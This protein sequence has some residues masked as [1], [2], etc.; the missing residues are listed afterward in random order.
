MELPGR[1]RNGPL[2]LPGQMLLMLDRISGF[3]PDEGRAGLG[4]VRAEKDVDAGE[5]F[6]KAHFFTDPVQPGSLG[7]EAMC[8]L[9][10][11]YL[12]ETDAGAGLPEPRFEPLL[13]GRTVVWK[14]RGQVT[15]SNELVIIDLEVT[16]AGIDADGC[17]YAVADASLWVDGK[18]IYQVNGL[19]SRVLSASVV[20]EEV[21][22][23][24][25]EPWLAD[26]CPTWTVPAVPATVIADRL[27]AAAAAHTGRSVAGLRQVHISR[28]LPVPARIRT[29][30]QVAGDEA[31]ATLYGW[32][33]SRTAALSRF[34]PVATSQVLLGDPPGPRP[35]VPEPL[36]DAAPVPDPYKSGA[37]FH[38]PRLQYVTSAWLG[39]TGASA[40]LDPAR[41]AMPRGLLHPG[42]LDGALQ[43]CPCDRMWRWSADIPR[44]VIAY[45]YRIDRLD[46][47]EPL[48]D[49]GTM[50]GEARFAGFE[51]AQPV[52]ELYLVAG[53]RVRVAMRVVWAL[54][55]VGRMS[56]VDAL[57]RRAFLQDRVAVPGVGLS[58]MDGEATWLDRQDVERWDW[59]PG[60]VAHAYGL[61][62]GARGVDHLAEIAVRDHV[63]SR[64]GVHPSRVLVDGTTAYPVDRPERVYYL[65]VQDP[66]RS[67]SGEL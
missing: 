66:G 60:T 36:P 20:R 47:Y 18:R 19:G 59:L 63:A 44:D 7:V 8:Q 38:G 1:Y 33:A 41:G 65:T 49:E 4:R 52:A 61:P 26:H 40:V 39:A 48:P 27:A 22:D 23:V 64:C 56:G 25:T 28:W 16:E 32:R 2:H 12:I 24:A 14:Y 55:P 67:G 57:L 15:P 34:E 58:T 51:G 21:L 9:L 62:P 42:L 53:V 45:P 13:S 37:M 31:T 54:L 3:W 10:Q 6:F 5:W 43:A 30:V 29:T 46:V 11:W 35:A 50:Y 17:P